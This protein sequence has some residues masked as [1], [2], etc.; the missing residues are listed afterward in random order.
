MTQQTKILALVEYVKK[1]FPDGWSAGLECK[2]CPL[3]RSD[4][5]SI[6]EAVCEMLG[7]MYDEEVFRDEL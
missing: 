3:N 5:Y 6:E 2:N 4:D 7:K 1:N